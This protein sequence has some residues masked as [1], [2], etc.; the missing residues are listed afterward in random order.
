M[1]KHKILLV[2]DE[3]NLE[4]QSQNYWSMKIMKSKSSNGQKH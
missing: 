1:T 2:D 3:E 4:K